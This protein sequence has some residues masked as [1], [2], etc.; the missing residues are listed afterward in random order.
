MA[1]AAALPTLSMR[2]IAP[3]RVDEA[4]D[5]LSDVFFDYP[6][7]RYV[8]GAARDTY[9]Q[10]LRTLLAFFPSARFIR[11][12]LVTGTVTADDVIV[13]VA[14]STL[15]GTRP[16]P[17]ALGTRREAV[18]R[19][20]GAN[21]RSRYE[22]YGKACEAFAIDRPTYHLSMIGVRRTHEGTGVGRRLLD[23]LHEQV[24]ARPTV[25]RCDAD[26]GE[27]EQ[28]AALPAFRV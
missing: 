7:M 18:W 10:R 11:H 13:G 12:E 6:V 21:A 28:R 26:D 1:C 9:A 19:E 2:E 27:P 15:P 20:L 14:N 25:G 24:P 22:T 16:S 17:A 5:V 8:I 3:D 4:V 23:A